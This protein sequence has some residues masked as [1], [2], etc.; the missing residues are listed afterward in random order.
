MNEELAP[1]LAQLRGVLRDRHD[2][3]LAL[4]FGSQA[5]GR[6]WPASFDT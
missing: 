3:H 5:T 1:L 2:V 4:L 6:A